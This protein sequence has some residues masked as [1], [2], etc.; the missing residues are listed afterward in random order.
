MIKHQF[1]IASA[2][3][4]FLGPNFR[5]AASK[6]SESSSHALVKTSTNDQYSAFLISN[7]V[8]FYRNNG[9]GSNSLLTYNS[10]FEFPQC[11]RENSFQCSLAW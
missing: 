7:V 11:R 5:V 10:R 9:G 6:D 4:L 8:S 1:L 2:I 3:L